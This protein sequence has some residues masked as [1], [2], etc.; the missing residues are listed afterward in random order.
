[1][2]KNIKP[3]TLVKWDYD[4]FPKEWKDRN[5]NKYSG[6]TFM[7]FGEING[8]PGHSFLQEMKT[9]KPYVLHTEELIPLED[10]EL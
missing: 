10:E 8:M 7:Y 3:L 4:S 5:P 2:K 6:R 1:M 9:G